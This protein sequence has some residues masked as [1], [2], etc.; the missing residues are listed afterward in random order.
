VPAQVFEQ[1]LADL[2]AA[3]IPA[4]VV[5]RLR[6]TLLEDQLFSDAALK[7]ALFGEEPGP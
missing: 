4:E 6:K 5:A 3:E 7:Q 2:M 1:F